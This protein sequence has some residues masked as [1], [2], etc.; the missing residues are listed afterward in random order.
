[1]DD[2]ERDE[3]DEVA[4]DT[5]HLDL[6]AGGVVGGAGH[7]GSASRPCRTNRPRLRGGR[8]ASAGDA[9]GWRAYRSVAALKAALADFVGD[10]RR[11]G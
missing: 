10:S 11:R 1:M 4:E 7:T 8:C 3:Q 5:E 9:M 2:L 6:D